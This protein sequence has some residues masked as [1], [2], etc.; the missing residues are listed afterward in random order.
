MS[1]ESRPKG[2]LVVEDDQ[3]LRVV[4]R[5]ILEHAG[6]Q[7]SEAR[8]GR[9]ALESIQGQKPDLILADMRMPI[10]NGVELVNH[11]RSD[12][13]TASIP[14]V[15]MSGLLTDSDGSSVA[16]AIV[17]KPF[18]PADLLGAIARLL[19]GGAAD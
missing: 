15:L 5:M 12:A 11:L 8:N 7:V 14:V 6:Y 3:S 19:G 13:R 16:D 10:M 17:A 4:I 9:A 18:E 2:V 1:T